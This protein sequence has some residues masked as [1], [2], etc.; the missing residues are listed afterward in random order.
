M[1]GEPGSS[2]AFATN[3][4]AVSAKPA[5]TENLKIAVQGL[6]SDRHG[7]T[8]EQSRGPQRPVD[9]CFDVRE[10]RHR[11]LLPSSL[12]ILVEHFTFQHRLCS[13]EV[14]GRWRKFRHSSL[15]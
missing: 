15:C 6:A 9:H 8:L 5:T 1:G 14:I 12:V 2:V 3:S 13:R 7:S 4:S 10:R 11:F